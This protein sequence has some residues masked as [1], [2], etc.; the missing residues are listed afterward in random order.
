MRDGPNQ[1]SNNNTGHIQEWSL[2]STQLLQHSKDKRHQDNTVGLLW[3]RR[4]DN[5]NNS[6]NLPSSKLPIKWPLRS[7]LHSKE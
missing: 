5:N 4:M 7:R 1:H 2:H 3:I 6:S